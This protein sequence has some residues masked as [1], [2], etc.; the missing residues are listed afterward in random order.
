MKRYNVRK[1]AR[2][3]RALA[4]FSVMSFENW[5]CDKRPEQPEDVSLPEQP[6]DVEA[7]RAYVERKQQELHALKG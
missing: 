6:E 3:D 1:T 4:R 7:Y 5:L 2:R